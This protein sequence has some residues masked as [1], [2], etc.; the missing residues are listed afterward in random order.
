MFGIHNCPS[1]NTKNLIAPYSAS[2]IMFVRRKSKKR[3]CP[4]PSLLSR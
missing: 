4:S 1:S 2:T 3:Y